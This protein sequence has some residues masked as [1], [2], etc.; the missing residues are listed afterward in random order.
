MA[1][2]EYG[3]AAVRAQQEKAA[4]TAWPHQLLVRGHNG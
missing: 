1:C 3:A 2:D 4:D